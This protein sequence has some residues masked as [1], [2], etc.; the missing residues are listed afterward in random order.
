MD[1]NSFMEIL[2]VKRGSFMDRN[3]FIKILKVKKFIRTQTLKKLKNLNN[4]GGR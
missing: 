3:S 2:K 1:R 4:S